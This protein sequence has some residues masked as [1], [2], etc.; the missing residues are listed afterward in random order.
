[1]T[2]NTLK[3][4]LLG[5]F[6]VVAAISAI[7]GLFGLS[8]VQKIDGELKYTVTNLTPSLDAVGRARYYYYRALWMTARGL[9]AL[10]V[11]D[12]AELR[13]ALEGRDA[14][15]AEVKKCFTEFEGIEMLAEEAP[16]FREMEAR[17]QA[18]ETVNESVWQALEAGD[19][20]KAW[21]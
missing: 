20:K 11:Q 13:R 21:E 3:L 6:A 15:L 16:P 7:V 9:N 2:F 4:K 17:Y 19:S 1:M 18:W 10:N 12:S 5:A 14:S 8:V